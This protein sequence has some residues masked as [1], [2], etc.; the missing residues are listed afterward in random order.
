MSKCAPEHQVTY[1]SGLFLDGA[2]SWWNLQV[3]TLGEAAAYGMTWD[4]MKELMRKKYC[5]RTEI[6]K[7]EIEFWNL[8]M[9]GPKI[10]EYVQRFHNL[11]RVVHYMVEPEF[12]RV[13][14]FI[15]GLTPQIMSIV[16]TSKPPTI[17]K[18]IDLSV[19]LTEEAIRLNKFSISEGK[20]KET[21]VESSG[22]NKRKFSNFKKGTQ[23]N[24]NS[25]NKRRDA[26]PLAEVRTGATSSENKGKGYMGTLPKC[27]ICQHHHT[28]RCRYGKCENC[29]KVGHAREACWYGTGRRN[30]GSG[31]NGN[32]NR[33]GN[34]N[35]NQIGNRNQGGNGNFA[36]NGNRGGSGNQ[37]GNG[38]RG[39]NNNQGGNGNGNGNG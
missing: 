5:S 28:G 21:H 29:G 26:N 20:K 36:G 32:G 6:Q 35:R 11:S 17:T 15:W 27:D 12:K 22:E 30:R 24:N 38:N 7:S 25:G 31:G 18:A 14:R 10:A 39:A 4:E 34:G 16:T 37:D 9:D 23:G 3:Q 1:I 2:L 13:E 19:A 8:K 33:G